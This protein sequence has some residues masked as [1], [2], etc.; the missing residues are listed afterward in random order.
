MKIKRLFNNFFLNLR[1]KKTLKLANIF[2]L[3]FYVFYIPSMSYTSKLNLISYVVLPLLGICSLVYIFYYKRIAFD[4]LK[5]SVVFILIFLGFS[6]FSTAFGTKQFSSLPRLY[7]VL[8]SGFVIFTSLYVFD[9]PKNAM[10]IVALSMFFFTLFYF[11]FSLLFARDRLIGWLLLKEDTPLTLMFF[12]KIGLDGGG[13]PN[14]ISS[15]FGTAAVLFLYLALFEKNHIFKLCLLPYLICFFA[16]VTTASRQFIIGL[17]VSSIF[18][19]IVA[20]HHKRILTIVSIASIITLFVLFMTLPIFEPIKNPILDGLGLLENSRGDKS[21]SS[22][23]LMQIEAFEIGGNKLFIGFGAD[24][25]ETISGWGGYAH[26]TYANLYVSFGII[27]LI[28]YFVPLVIMLIEIKRAK[29]IY[30]HLAISMLIYYIILGFFIVWYKDKIFF[31]VYG[32]IIYFYVII[33]KTTSKLTVCYCEI[34]I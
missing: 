4:K 17:T 6:F 13:G 9:K 34:N 22:R 18:L 33:E 11:G 15:Y 19:Y 12:R 1:T 20:V 30:F 7:L 10:I 21:A 14:I 16:G 27:G 5:I 28:I 25:F 31:I 3:S 24:G 2:L 29:S 8:L 32:L 26:N 23:I